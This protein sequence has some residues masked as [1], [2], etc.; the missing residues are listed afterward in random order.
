[1]IDR[2]TNPKHAMAHR[3]TKRGITVCEEW[4]NDPWAFIR[5]VEENLGPK[6]TPEHTLDR[7]PD[8][9]GNYEP[10]NIRW[11]SRSEQM[12]NTERSIQKRQEV[13]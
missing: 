12:Y 2:C 8:N 10:N 7:Y 9:D 6:P 1:M 3:Y 13:V 4:L 5:Y 11:A